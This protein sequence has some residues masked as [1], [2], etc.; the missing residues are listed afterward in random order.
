MSYLLIYLKKS[1]KTG[2]KT[3][4]VHIKNILV[5]H[6][7]TLLGDKALSYA[8]KIAKLSGAT[9][10][11]LHSVEPIPGPPPLIL[12]KKQDSKMR[13]VVEQA[14]VRGIREEPAKTRRLLQV[15]GDQCKLHRGGWQA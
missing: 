1:A 7:G 15:K 8:I 9:V 13:K 5:P 12:A 10:N 14:A 3:F 11:I 4:P 2:L 6:A